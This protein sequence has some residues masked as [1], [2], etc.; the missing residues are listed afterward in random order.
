MTETTPLNTLASLLEGLQAAAAKTAPVAVLVPELGGSVYVMPVT[1]A[2]W[3]NP[4]A[5]AL[6]DSA[7]DAHKRAWAVAR[8]ISDDAGRRLV[9]PSNAAALDLFAVLPWEVSHRILQAAGVMSDGEQK[10]A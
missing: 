10:N 8:W 9:A 7:S 4:D 3:L 5:Q 2:E 1:T 6:P